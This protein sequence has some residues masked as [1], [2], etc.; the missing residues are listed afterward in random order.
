MNFAG[1]GERCFALN[2]DDE[3][4]GSKR[5]EVHVSG[6]LVLQG[7]PVTASGLIPSNGTHFPCRNNVNMIS[8][9]HKNTDIHNILFCI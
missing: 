4:G 6:F 5:K 3:G 7:A 8:L 9:E 1:V 2:G